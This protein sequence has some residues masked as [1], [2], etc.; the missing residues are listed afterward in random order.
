MRIIAAVTSPELSACVG[1]GTIVKV[2]HQDARHLLSSA[3]ASVVQR[4]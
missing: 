1:G 3:S 4:V 2:C